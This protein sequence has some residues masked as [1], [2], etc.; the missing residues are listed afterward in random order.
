MSSFLMSRILNLFSFLDDFLNEV[1]RARLPLVLCYPISYYV[2]FCD[3][4]I[5]YEGSKDFIFTRC[6]F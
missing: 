4:G 5:C 2:A 1:I 6:K 3:N